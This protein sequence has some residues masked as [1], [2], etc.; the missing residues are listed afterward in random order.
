MQYSFLTRFTSAAALSLAAGFSALAAPAPA[1]DR[2][3]VE[4]RV[5]QWQ[6]TAEERRWETI[7]WCG[8]LREA[9]E[10]GQK[11]RRPVFLF[12]LDGRMNVGRC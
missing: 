11:H 3:W 10:L 5:R 1:R 6:P 2:A 7:G 9:L 12:T 8:T 4:E